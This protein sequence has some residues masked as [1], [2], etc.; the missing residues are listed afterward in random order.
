[1]VLANGGRILLAAQR[2]VNEVNIFE[3]P[4]EARD[5]LFNLLCRLGQTC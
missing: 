5:V 4:A 1:V 2:E 3:L